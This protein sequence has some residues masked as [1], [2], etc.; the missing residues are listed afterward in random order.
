MKQAN[1]NVHDTDW[2]K[3]KEKDCSCSSLWLFLTNYNLQAGFF[4]AGK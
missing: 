4:L 3:V 1:D 2:K